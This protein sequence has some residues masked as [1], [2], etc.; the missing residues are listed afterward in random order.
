MA[1]KHDRPHLRQL[2]GF[3][4]VE[5]LRSVGLVRDAIVGSPHA[6]DSGTVSE[7][8]SSQFDGAQKMEA[9]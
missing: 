8:G 9:S 2:R 3:T 7:H 5:R 4:R 1:E 6:I